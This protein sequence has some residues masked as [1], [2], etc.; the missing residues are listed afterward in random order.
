[1]SNE[2]TSTSEMAEQDWDGRS[3]PA[4]IQTDMVATKEAENKGIEFHVSMRDYTMRDMEELIIEAAATQMVGKFGNDRLAKE[5]EA[6]T[7][8]LVTAKADKALESVT[9]EIIDQ[10]LMPKFTY[11]KADAAP[12]TMRELIGL[13]GRQ[14]LTE[15]VDSQGNVSD[16]SSY[17]E[18]SRI[19]HLVEKYMSVA[20]KKE[21]EQATGA[22][23]R[24][25]QAAIK[26]KHDAMLAAE[27]KRF[28]E[29]LA[30]VTA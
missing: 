26:A 6:K 13:T 24:E 30:K 5:I 14:Y 21:I 2:I 20:F 29:A 16:R 22:A 25:V 19:Q 4:D 1:M 23:V 8:A 10:P 7:I 11:G 18:K 9:A 28:H 12:V 3:E 27:K 17:N 15:L